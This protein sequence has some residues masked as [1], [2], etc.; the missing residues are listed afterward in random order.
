VTAKTVS[1]IVLA[2]IV[3]LVGIMFYR[4]MATF[5]LP[6]FL[7]ALLVIIF[8]P[9][10]TWVLEKVKDRHRLASAITTLAI[11]LIVLAPAGWVCTFALVQ[12]VS[13]VTKFDTEDF[14]QRLDKARETLGLQMPL[15][16]SLHLIDNQLDLLIAQAERRGQSNGVRKALD[17]TLREV[18]VIEEQLQLAQRGGD[19]GDFQGPAIDPATA[20]AALTSVKPLRAA[21]QE[22]IEQGLEPGDVDYVPELQQAQLAFRQLTSDLLGGPMTA[23]LIRLVNPS[24]ADIRQYNN[25]VY[26]KLQGYLLSISGT[27]PGFV[28]KMLLDVGIMVLGVYFFF[29]D[30]PAMVRSVMMLSPLEEEYEQELLAEFERISRSVVIATL[31]TALVQGILA[32]IGFYFCGIQSVILLTVLTIV[33]ALIPFIGAMAVWLPVS[34]WLFFIEERTLAAVLLF[35]YGFFVIS[36]SDNILK[37]L[38]LHGQSNMHPLLALLSILGGVEALGPIGIL[39]G[40][41]IVA[42]LQA[43]LKILNKELG[44]MDDR[45]PQPDST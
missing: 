43:L 27:A 36:T 37:P 16:G 30:G 24:E 33:L 39:V 28:A 5:L 40:P 42:F 15:A 23:G 21:L 12:G 2:A 4:V 8:R 44:R 3:V 19:M 14:H 34:M 38:L 7:A 13:L 45:L 26:D 20:E 29:A 17:R 1:F 25:F 9:L 31:V 22:V 41:M 10:H 11:M 35:L 6:L 18:E 32:G